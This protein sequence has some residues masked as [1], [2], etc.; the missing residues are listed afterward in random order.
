MTE[1]ESFI[2]L[3]MIDGLGPSRLKALLDHFGSPQKVLLAGQ[4][5]L[6]AVPNIGKDC[7][8]NIIAGRVSIDIK[9]EL[10]LIE[11]NRVKIVTIFDESYPKNL[12]E[13]FDPPILLYVKGQIL[14]LDFAAIAIVGSRRASYYGQEITQRISYDLAQKGMTI[15]SGMARGIDTA[16]HRGAIKAKGRTIAVWGS[17]L[18]VVYPP[19]NARLA[20]E[21]EPCGALISEFPMQTPP[22]KEN[23]PRRNRI[24]SGLSLGVVVVEAAQRSGA[25]ITAGFALEQGREVFA[26]PGRAGSFTS[27][28]THSLIKEGAK[29]VETS[30]DI[31]EELAPVLE[32]YSRDID[33][34]PKLEKS[35]EPVS[36]EPHPRPRLNEEERMIYDSLSEEPSHIDEVVG[37]TNLP[38]SQVLSTLTKLQIRRLVKELPGKMFVRT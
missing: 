28:G 18:G 13:I 38:P 24:I 36:D 19:E 5:E 15:V 25:L 37:R 7:A 17:G 20:D 1:V 9:K 8:K 23:F 26:V 32:R 33:I 12:K 31:M 27:K 2:I 3:N 11:R 14:P 34:E 4:K 21:I 16:A 22:H 6:L 30:E 10:D 29:L 35:L